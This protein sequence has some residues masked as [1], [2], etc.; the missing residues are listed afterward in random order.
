MLQPGP[1]DHEPV[2][3]APAPRPR[4]AWNSCL[5]A[6]LAGLACVAIITA[7]VVIGGGDRLIRALE[8]LRGE[9]QKVTVQVTPGEV[10]PVLKLVVEELH[11]SVHTKRTGPVLGG[12]TQSLFRHVI[13]QGT[14]TACFNLEDKAEQFQVEPDP[15]DPEHVTVRLPPPEYCHAGID[16]AEFFDEAGIGV[17]ATNEVNGLLLED[18]Q[19]QLYVAAD[20]QK[21]LAKAQERGAVQVKELLYKLGFKRVDVFF[22]EPVQ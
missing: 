20:S 3:V 14:I 22:A 21:L 15:N 7:I 9:P 18:A 5:I 4:A 11:T 1:L 16:R 12:V 13:A 8:V 17:A 6:A 2:D 10:L 19:K